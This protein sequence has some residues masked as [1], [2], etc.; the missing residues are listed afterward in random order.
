MRYLL[1]V[2][3]IALA[4]VLML[5]LGRGKGTV[6]VEESVAALDKAKLSVLPS[7]L[8]QVE[9]A[10]EAYADEHGAY[11]DELAGLVPGYLRNADSLVDPWGTRLRLQKGERKGAFLVSAGPDRKFSTPDDRRRSL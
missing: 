7:Q 1:L 6:P 3:L 11:P 8:L 2:V 9:A 4:V 10:L 5:H